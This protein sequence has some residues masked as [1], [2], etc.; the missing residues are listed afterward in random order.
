MALQYRIAQSRRYFTSLQLRLDPCCRLQDCGSPLRP[1]AH[2]FHH[3]SA[4]SGKSTPRREL[5]IFQWFDRLAQAI[6][7]EKQN[8]SS[9]KTLDGAEA[10]A[11]IVSASHESYDVVGFD[12]IEASRLG[13][14]LEDAVQ[15]VPEDTGKPV[16]YCH[17]H[18]EMLKTTQCTGRNHPTVGKLVA[19]NREEVI[20]E[21]RGTQGL[22]RCHFPRIGFLISK[23]P[24]NTTQ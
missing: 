5:I 15:V 19:L 12:A 18:P 11:K 2:S 21:V 3:Q 23:V 4:C 16:F 10:A 13:T 24:L 20:L 8:K 17:L 9:P 14:A 7:T 22:V 1:C 6:E